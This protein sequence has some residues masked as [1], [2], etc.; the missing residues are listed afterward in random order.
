[1]QKSFSD[2][3]FAGVCGGLAAA[4][5]INAWLVRL[6]F[7]VLTLLSLG[8]FAVLYLLL[9][10]LVPQES[11]ISTRRRRR[12]FSL[13][14]VLI[15]AVLVIAAWVGRD[16]GS[17]RAPNGADL[18]WPAALAVLSLVFFLRQVRA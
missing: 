10:W 15:L 17:L 3:V 5:H 12:R 2:R 7:V 4:L 9:W 6:V 11:F 1:M 8:A 18:F 14:F 16:L 13:L